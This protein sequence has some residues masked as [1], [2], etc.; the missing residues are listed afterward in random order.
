[1]DL[2]INLILVRFCFSTSMLN[3]IP[4]HNCSTLPTSESQGQKISGKLK[5]FDLQLS[6]HERTMLVYF[7][8]NNIQYFPPTP[9]GSYIDK[10]FFY[11]IAM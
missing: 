5:Y 9:I 10:C 7:C 4:G 1:M 3:P 6:Y 2:F 8:V 11:K